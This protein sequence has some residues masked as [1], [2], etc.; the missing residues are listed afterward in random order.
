MFLELGVGENTLG[1]IKY[2]P[3]Q[4]AIENP[5]AV[6]I[7]VN[8][9]NASAPE[10]IRSRSICLEGDTGSAIRGILKSNI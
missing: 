10:E 7:C 4:M 9:D 3:W 5:N 1:I 2:L 6:Y 8:K